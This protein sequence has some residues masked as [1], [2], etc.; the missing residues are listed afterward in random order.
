MTE[1]S[2]RLAPGI[3]ATAVK[4]DDGKKAE[5][6]INEVH[7]LADRAKNQDEQ[8]RAS[9]G[10]ARALFPDWNFDP[11]A[12]RPPEPPPPAPGPNS[13]TGS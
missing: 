10:V 13:D 4:G 7:P 5:V 6:Y 1:T 8:H 2:R 12:K 3:V 11:P 9:L